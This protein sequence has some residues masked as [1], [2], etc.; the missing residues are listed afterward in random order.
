MLEHEAGLNWIPE[1]VLPTQF[2]WIIC[3]SLIPTEVLLSL[4]T[5][6]IPMNKFGDQIQLPQLLCWVAVLLGFGNF[7]GVLVSILTNKCRTSIYRWRILRWPITRGP[8]LIPISGVWWLELFGGWYQRRS[9]VLR[10]RDIYMFREFCWRPLAGA[11][12]IGGTSH[13]KR[14][15]MTGDAHQEIPFRRNY[16]LCTLWPTRYRLIWRGLLFPR[17]SR[18]C[19]WTNGRRHTTGLRQE[20]AFFSELWFVW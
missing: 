13:L 4:W 9:L 3:G 11:W 1:V 15:I 17:L 12:S 20:G 18:R 10:T 16:G 5:P 19:L 6:H 7:S 14:L 2:F 8:N